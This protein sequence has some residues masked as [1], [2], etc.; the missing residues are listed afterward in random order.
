MAV[1][2]DVWKF[3]LYDYKILILTENS[4][5]WCKEN[6]KKQHLKY[7]KKKEELNPLDPDSYWD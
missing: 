7:F 2:S 3:E 4:S 1:D 5:K 6:T